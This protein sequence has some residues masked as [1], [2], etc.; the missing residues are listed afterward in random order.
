MSE[1]VKKI[2]M[3][4]DGLSECD[5]DDVISNFKEDFDA[6]ISSEDASLSEAED[7]L[8]DYFGLEPDYIMDFL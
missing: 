2:L 6:L 1:R 4:R 5:A 3:E 8:S 7:L